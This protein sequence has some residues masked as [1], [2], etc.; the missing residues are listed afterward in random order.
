MVVLSALSTS[1][2]R[3]NKDFSR[4]LMQIAGYQLITCALPQIVL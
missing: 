2:I 4:G 3:I 1:L